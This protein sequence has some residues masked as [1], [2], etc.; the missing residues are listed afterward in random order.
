MPAVKELI[1]KPRSAFLLVKCP[2]CEAERVIFSHSKREIRCSN[3]GELLA[4]PTGGKAIIYG[5]I[6]KRLDV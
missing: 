6:V 1:M 4:E 2:K 5:K 3:C